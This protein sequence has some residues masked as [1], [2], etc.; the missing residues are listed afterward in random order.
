MT[1]VERFY[2][3]FTNQYGYADKS[4]SMNVSNELL[5]EF[6][7][8][9]PKVIDELETHLIKHEINDFYIKIKNLKYLCEYSDDFNSYWLLL[10][11]TSGGI[12]RLLVNPTPDHAT[13]VYIYYFNK[14][15]GRRNLR[16][17][18]WF[19]NH[20]WTFLDKITNMKSD[21]ELNSFILE[22]IDSLTNYFQRYKKELDFF[23]ID[24]KE[25]I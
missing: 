18:N 8:H 15:G 3:Y 9:L 20:R 11:S 17:E 1:P 5:E 6:T 14:Y 23:V 16:N 2:K 4:K 19:E 10:R 21:D 13:E 12:N 24:L 25:L 22:K 7:N